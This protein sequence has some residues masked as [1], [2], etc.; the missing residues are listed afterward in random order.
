MD[1]IVLI[2]WESL[3]GFVVIY[4]LQT[5][6]VQREPKDSIKAKLLKS[7]QMNSKPIPRTP[8]L[9]HNES[10]EIDLAGDEAMLD[11]MPDMENVVKIKSRSVSNASDLPDSP[12][13]CVETDVQLQTGAN[14]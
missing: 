9:V 7:K 13:T 12:D 14:T 10:K 5:L 1:D 8:Q 11:D 4:L 2:F 6:I 3:F